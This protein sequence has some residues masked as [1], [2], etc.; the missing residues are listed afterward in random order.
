[1]PILSLEITVELQRLFDDTCYK[2]ITDFIA[3]ERILN[4][5]SLKELVCV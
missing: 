1:M 4:C 5:N 3:A 2:I